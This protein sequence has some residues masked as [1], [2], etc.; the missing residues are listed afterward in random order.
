MIEIKFYSDSR[1]G[2]H[3]TLHGHASA[4]PKGEDL[5]CA[6]CTTL[7]YT[8]AQAVKDMYVLGK[9]IKSPKIKIRRG[10][11]KII[12]TPKEESLAEALQVFRTVQCGAKVLA[13]NYP[14]YVRLEMMHS[15]N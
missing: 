13:H 6:A 11:A 4:A 14:K 12:A 2:I 8:A 1:G 3:M 15:K 10:K 9:L 7:A 5:I